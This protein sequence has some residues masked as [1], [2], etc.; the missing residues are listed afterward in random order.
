MSSPGNLPAST[1]NKTTAFFNNY[2]NQPLNTS[3]NINDA[4][5]GYF[6]SITGSK[7][8]G[9]TLANTVLYT[10]LSQG[11]DPMTIID[12]MRSLGKN[13]LNVYLTV[14]LNLNRANTSL[15]GI[16]NQPETN[17]YIQRAILP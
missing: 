7:S 16:T 15:L 9:E 12:E 10:A 2:F 13:E 5:I 1:K 6:Q 8:S 14:F 4:V 11:I 17:K 3:S